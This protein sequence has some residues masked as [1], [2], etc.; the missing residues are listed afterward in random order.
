MASNDDDA[1]IEEELND[2]EGDDLRRSA[3]RATRRRVA[4]ADSRPAPV[5]TSHPAQRSA[6]RGEV[7]ERGLTR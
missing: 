2:P 1:L 6:V 5:G 3:R 7:L 4:A